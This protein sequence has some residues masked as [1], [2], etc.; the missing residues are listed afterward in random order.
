M[1]IAPSRKRRWL[2]LLCVAMIVVLPIAVIWTPWLIAQYDLYRGRAELQRFQVDPALNWLKN[3]QRLDPDNA[4]AHFLLA[5]VYRRKGEF[6]DM[7]QHLEEARRLGFP[8]RRI[9]RERVL[10]VA[11]TGRVHEVQPNLEGM[12]ISP[13]D[14]GPEICASY[15]SGYCLSFDFDAASALLDAWSK[16][17]PEQPEPHYRRGHLW[18]SRNEWRNAVEAYSKC[19]ELDPSRFKA[20]LSLAQ[21]L[22]KMSES[23]KAEPHFRRCVK[24]APDNLEAWMGWGSCLLTLG[25]KA[26][27]QTAL[28]HVVEEA[29]D[30]FEARRQLGELEL[31]LGHPHEALKW[32][33]PLAEKWPEDTVVANLMAQSLQEIGK[34]AEA[35]PYWE[36]VRR[37]EKLLARLEV[38]TK[39]INRHPTDVALRYEIGTLLIRYR[40]RE[41]GVGWL[42]SLLQYDPNHVE[43]HRALADYYAKVGDAKMAELH[44]LTVDDL[45][46]ARGR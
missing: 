9:E 42:R 44:R 38:L 39:E 24:E 4:E 2:A 40:S 28:H 25:Q 37:G 6:E 19:L 26:E 41:D 30:H 15:V 22:L 8:S 31:Q 10:A 3:G 5:R 17:Y 1:R 27:A 43:T 29:P 32:V 7:A 34:V 35:K 46:A 12:L 18:Y 45:E 14:D 11:Q 36:S 33:E 13:D 23:E 21:C 20:R 16:D